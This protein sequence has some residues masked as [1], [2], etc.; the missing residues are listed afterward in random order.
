MTMRNY[1]SLRSEVA[2]LDKLIAMTPE[3]AVI[4]RMSLESRRSRVQEELE[5]YELPAR[6]PAACGV[7][8]SGKPVVDRRG[9]DARFGT[10]VVEA[11][12]DSIVFAGASQMGPLSDNGPVPNRE[13]YGLLI[14]G[15]IRGSF[16][17]EIE[18]AGESKLTIQGHS[19]VELGIVQVKSILKASVSGDE[20]LDSA[21]AEAH[22]RTLAKLQLF[23]KTMESHGAYC[24]LSFKDDVFRFSNVGQVRQSLESLSQDNA[25]V[26]EK[27]ISGVFRGYLPANRQAEFVDAES[28]EVLSGRVLASVRNAEGINEILNR[29]A[30]IT[31]RIRQVGN[32]PP[33]YTI[34]NYRS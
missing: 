2:E 13:D 9:I 8:F 3:S 16:G 27:E 18:E 11:F 25:Q 34:T 33:K 31:V 1:R 20:A 23:L 5:S 32:R 26:D 24:A 21:L 10:K 12:T 29:R 14:T 15:A 7:I 22:P 6:W 17:F 19:P 30:V 4:D 28:R